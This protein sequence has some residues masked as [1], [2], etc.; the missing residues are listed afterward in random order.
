MVSDGIFRD[1]AS[2]LGYR[3]TDI[4]EKALEVASKRRES[5]AKVTVLTHVSEIIPVIQKT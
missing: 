5:N 1:D 2:K 4:V 3:S